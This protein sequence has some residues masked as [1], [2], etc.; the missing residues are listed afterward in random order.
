MRS[1]TQVSTLHRYETY[2]SSLLL[3]VHI[4]NIDAQICRVCRRIPAL[5]ALHIAK[6][7]LE[8]LSTAGKEL[9]TESLKAVEMIDLD[10]NSLHD[11]HE[12]RVLA[13]LPKYDPKKKR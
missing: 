6:N 13:R 2:F 7:R 5:E 10:D 11:W 12:I 8:S 1:I 4:G 9:V 3:L